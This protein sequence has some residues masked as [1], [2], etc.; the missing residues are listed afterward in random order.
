MIYLLKMMMFDSFLLVYQRVLCLNP[1]K[2]VVSVGSIPILSWFNFRFFS[3]NPNVSVV[4]SQCS[5]VHDAQVTFFLLDTSLKNGQIRN[6][7]RQI[8]CLNHSFWLVVWNILDVCFP[9]VGNFHPSQL[10]NSIIFQMGWLKPPTRE[11]HN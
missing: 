2:D 3:F 7:G 4:R 11:Y 6:L 10:T 8:Q 1:K 5:F 9:S